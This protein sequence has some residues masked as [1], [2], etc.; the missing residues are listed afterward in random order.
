MHI[1]TSLSIAGSAVVLRGLPPTTHKHPP[2]TFPLPSDHLLHLIQYNVFRALLSNKHTLNTVPDDPTMCPI[3]EPCLDDTTIYPSNPDIPPCLIPTTLQR[4]RYHPS[5]VNVIPFP[6][7]RDNLIMREGHFDHWELMRDL[8]GELMSIMPVPKRRNTPVTSTEQEFRRF[9]P[10]ISGSDPDE[11]TGGR[12]G[13]I[14]W[15]EPHE[16]QSW[17]ATP[18]FL[19]KWAWV[20]EGC[21]ELVEMSNRWR[22][23]RGEE[24]MRISVSKSYP[25]PLLLHVTSSGK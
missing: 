2:F 3:T 10:L 6:R 22:M 4:T 5:W 8:I 12:T 7:I 18:G 15:G 9:L 23:K 1:D 20:V 25:P 21:E 16:M 24:P 17:E 11:V 19:A 14:V 13:L